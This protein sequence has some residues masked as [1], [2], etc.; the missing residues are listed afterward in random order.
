MR[1]YLGVY[2]R[3]IV[4]AALAGL[5][6]GF[7]V[8]VSWCWPFALVALVPMYWI[9]Y[10]DEL[11][12]RAIFFLGWLFG[13]SLMGVSLSFTF[14]T[15]PLDW[16][17]VESPPAA[18]ILITSVWLLSS[19]ILGVFSGLFALVSRFLLRRTLVDV[20]LLPVLWVGFEWMRM[21]GFTLLMWG[22]GSILVPYFSFGMLGFALTQ[23]ETLLSLARYGGVY[24]LSFAAALVSFA[25]WAFV[26]TECKHRG[27]VLV[28][29]GALVGVGLTT[30][31]LRPLAVSPL[32]LHVV[33]MS[34]MFPAVLVQSE[35]QRI[36][37]AENIEAELHRIAS[38]GD[39]DIVLLPEGSA[40]LATL[41]AAHRNP[42]A[43]LHEI[44][45]PKEILLID[46]EYIETRYGQGER[47][48]FF[49]STR[50]EIASR[51]KRLLVPFG[52]YM[53]YVWSTIAKLGGMGDHL[54]VA[55]QYRSFSA[56]DSR[57]TPVEYRGVSLIVLMCSEAL[58]PGAYRTG[59]H[60]GGPAALLL[61]SS[62]AVFHGNANLIHQLNAMARVQ[63]A[64]Q[65][66][67]FY[68][69]TNGAPAV[70]LE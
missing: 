70:T 32:S 8:T 40:Y 6:G 50:G 47:L 55:R 57:V 69:S 64:W 43:V 29:C 65:G 10:R 13:F 48:V 31:M 36:A 61:A 3:A 20:L 38:T 54:A 68:Q 49:S 7:A 18:G 66:A 52:E 44:F 67:P 51:T 1:N 26:S 35:A 22:P 45:G 9:V 4:Y 12:F 34:T 39:A 14:D 62:L 16:V 30:A 23:S 63:S 19:A 37:H 33:T 41:E 2:G 53:P 42:L 21:W 59:T 60:G 56:S 58:Q 25:V 5:A 11:T 17:G 28:A 46:T 24:V 27:A 15:Y